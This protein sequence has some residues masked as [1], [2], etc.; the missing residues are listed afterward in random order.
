MIRML[1]DAGADMEIKD[2]VND[3]YV[4]SYNHSDVKFW[5]YIERIDGV[6]YCWQYVSYSSVSA[7]GTVWLQGIVL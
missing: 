7:I 6:W 3:V 4:F 2:K 1:L 5:L